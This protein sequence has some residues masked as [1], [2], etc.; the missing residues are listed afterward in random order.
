MSTK[1]IFWWLLLLFGAAVLIAAFLLFR[2]NTPTDILTLNILVSLIIYGLIFLAD[3]IPLVNLR[4]KTQKQIGA[5]GI[6][7]F[8]VAIYG[9]AAI[10]V[11]LLSNLAFHLLFSTQLIIHAILLFMLFL[12]IWITKHT[13]DKV[14]DVYLQETQ[15]RSRITEM[16]T[17]MRNLKDVINNTVGLPEYFTKR[18]DSLDENL[19]FISPAGNA[20]AIEMESAFI[21]TLREIKFAISDFSMNE[22]R[23]ESNL[24]KAERIYQNRK[25]VYST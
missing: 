5:L 20:E 14:Q 24:T 12:G 17:E 4:D 7:W 8:T 1:K 6:A 3:P 15:N 23:I 11:M 13:A 18:M 2:G 10:A 21:E 9:V 25:S 16:K 19:R 22:E